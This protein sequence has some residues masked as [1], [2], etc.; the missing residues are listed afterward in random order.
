MM[1]REH[2]MFVQ[3]NN[4]TTMFNL[5]FA[6]RELAP[7]AHLLKLG[8]MGGNPNLDVPERFFEIDYRGRKDGSRFAGR[9]QAGTTGPRFMAPTTSCSPPRSGVCGRPM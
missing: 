9:R 7:E 6:I 2:A 3:M 1:D 5:L 4:L 8:T